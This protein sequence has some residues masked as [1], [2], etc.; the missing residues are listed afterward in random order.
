MKP[1]GLVLILGF[2]G[3]GASPKED[4][5]PVRIDQAVNEISGF[6]QGFVSGRCADGEF[7]RRAMLDLVGYPPN[8][9]E[10]R[11]FSADPAPDKRA[12]K[13]DQL[14]GGGRHADFWARR[15]MSVFFGNYH[16]IRT[17][18]LKGLEPEQR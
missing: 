14:L 7:L 13:I 11:I 3:A 15:W 4:P 6:R 16:E 1:A 2:L 5:L 17:E 8:A 9:E 10:T 18:A 12:A